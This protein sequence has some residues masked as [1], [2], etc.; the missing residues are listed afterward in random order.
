MATTESPRRDVPHTPRPA[1]TGG[2]RPNAS[3]A[4]RSPA[5]T[6]ALRLRLLGP[7]EAQRDGEPLH[8]GGAKP[9]TVLAALL[10]ARGRVVADTELTALLWGDRPPATCSAQI[11]TYASRVRRL[12]PGVDVERR[13]P[14]YLVRLPEHGVHVDLFAFQERAARGAAALAAGDPRTAADTLRE[15]LACWRG[16]ALGGVCDP[17]VDVE[18][19]RLEEERLVALERRLDADLELGRHAELIPELIAEIASHPLREGLRAKLMTALYRAGRQ[20]DALAAYRAARATLAE[21]LGLDPCAELQRLHQAMLTG[22]PSL[23]PRPPRTPGPPRPSPAAESVTGASTIGAPVPGASVPVPLSAAA[24]PEGRGPAAPAPAPASVPGP[25][26]APAPAAASASASAS[27]SGPVPVPVPVPAPVPVPVPAELPPDPSHV[28]GR[29]QEVTRLSTA[30]SDHR[31]RGGEPAVHAVTGMVGVGKSAVALRAAHRVRHR[32]PDG[33]VHL[34]LRGSGPAPLDPAEALAELLRLL[35]ADPDRLPSGLDARVRAYR[36]RIADRRLLLVLDDAADERQVRPLLPVTEGCAVLITS[37]RALHALDGAV[38]TVLRPLTRADAHGLFETLAGRARTAAEPRAADAVVEACAG[39]PLALRIAGLRAAAR[40]S[41]PLSA[42]ARRL[43]ADDRV[44][45]ELALGDLSL[46]DRLRGGYRRLA[47]PERRALRFL[48]ALGPRP[49]TPETAARA[50][51][52]GPDRAEDLLAGLAE[53]HWTEQAGP[54]GA[55]GHRLH[56]LVGLFARELLAREEGG[57][58]LPLPVRAADGGAEPST[59]PSARPAACGASAPPRARTAGP[60]PVLVPMPVSPPTPLRPACCCP[61]PTPR[62]VPTPAAAAIPAQALAQ[63][64]VRAE[65]QARA[66]TE[67]KTGTGA[68]PGP[69]TGPGTGTGTGTAVPAPASPPVPLL[70]PVLVPAPRPV[71]LPLRVAGHAPVPLP[72]PSPFP[73][74]PPVP[75]PMRTVGCSPAPPQ[76]PGGGSSLLLPLP[77]PVRSVPDRTRTGRAN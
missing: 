53:A 71:A 47:P 65:P 8:L 32:Y 63:A 31:S 76:S 75:H 29:D 5:P 27:A 35:G 6:G 25:A 22:H 66:E 16:E 4:P 17:L 3:G 56:P 72:S 77:L 74:P 51:G 38:R 37:R 58:P 49:V 10:I 18:R 70:L 36:T 21:E 46:H 59:L 24:F 9:R 41:W 33:Q 1:P 19:D 60:Q 14:G 26:S 42:L 34:D 73:A 7:V 64:Q 44:L 68:G 45:D 12:L 23:Q 57:V 67:T 43:T 54:G 55:P 62:A 20:A 28:V 30:L 61:P 11:H 2:P 15:A 40:P 52:V 39:L 13:R 48:S 50:L 69:G